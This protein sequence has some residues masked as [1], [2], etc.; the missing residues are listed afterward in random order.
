MTDTLRKIEPLG[1]LLHGMYM[2]E[3]RLEH[4][5][6]PSFI[7]K[8]HNSFEHSQKYRSTCVVMTG[9]VLTNL[10]TILVLLSR[11]LEECIH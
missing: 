10:W 5:E 4:F 11:S 8:D 9:P 3:E 6:E 1:S 7:L 2:R